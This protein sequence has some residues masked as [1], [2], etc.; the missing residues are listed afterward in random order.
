VSVGQKVTDGGY[1]NNGAT[2]SPNLNLALDFVDNS[3]GQMVAALKADGL[4]NSTQIIIT[5]KHGQSPKNRA[6]YHRIAEDNSS[7]SGSLATGKESIVGF[8]NAYSAQPLAAETSDDVS[9]DWWQD[10]VNGPGNV[11]AA[12]NADPTTA[13]IL[14]IAHVYAGT[15]LDNLFGTPD[16]STNYLDPGTRVPDVVIQPN[17]GV[18]Y[19]LSTSK[20]AEHGGGTMD[21]RNVA[22]L[23]VNGNGFSHAKTVWANVTTTQVAP[24]ILAWLGLNPQSLTAVQQT[25]ITVLP[26]H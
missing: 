12:L 8:L 3:L 11:V 13:N 17:P 23:V 4:L 20:I 25:H 18:T 2:F 14:S 15:E 21:D 9:L 10:P 6:L 22:L 5:A 19:S 1:Y 26:K 16:E 24:T 7:F